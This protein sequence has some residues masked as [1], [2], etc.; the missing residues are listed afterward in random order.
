MARLTI[1]LE[2]GFTGDTVA[3]SV[4][5]TERYRRDGVKTKLQIGLAD[6]FETDVPPGPAA[7]EVALPA[8]QITG[9]YDADAG[10][11]LFIGVSL[12]N[13]A[14]AFRQSPHTFGYV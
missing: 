8:K 11:D 9:R 10:A 1:S 2:E 14:L 4:N 3:V 6:Q 12:E 5:G 7:I 13:G